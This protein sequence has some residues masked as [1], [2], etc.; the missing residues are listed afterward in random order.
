MRGSPEAMPCVREGRPR[1]TPGEDEA[2]ALSDELPQAD[3]S[4]PAGM[5]RAPAVPALRRERRENCESLRGIAETM[6]QSGST[7]ANNRLP[8]GMRDGVHQVNH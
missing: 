8:A 1:T 3:R 6:P 2:A 5:S 4:D 7:S